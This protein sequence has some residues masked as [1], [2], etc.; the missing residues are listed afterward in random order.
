[1]RRFFLLL[2]FSLILCTAHAQDQQ[3][4]M[5]TV[6][7]TYPLVA[8]AK[9]HEG[10]VTLHAII[11]ETGAVHDLHVVS[12]PKEFRQAAIDAVGNW[13]YRPYLLNGKPT[14]VDTTIIVNFRLG[15]KQQKAA[16]MAKAQAELAQQAQAN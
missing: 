8:K 9:G 1:M 7:P 12:G 16:A 13:K 14:P 2:A 15:D 4:P 11:G 5:S 3:I 10:T 6:P